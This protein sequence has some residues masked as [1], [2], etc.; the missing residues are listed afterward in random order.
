MWNYYWPLLLIVGS[1]VIY[2]LT[3]KN[4]PHSVDPFLSLTVTYVI[5]A[6]ASLSLYLFSNGGAKELGAGLAELNLTSFLLGLAVVGLETGYIYL[7]RAG[8]DMGK[9]PLTA[10]IALTTILIIIGGLFFAET[11][12][13]KQFVGILI[14]FLGLILITGK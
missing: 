1:N 11:I 14:C 6:G 5:A 8:W 7:Y 12:S 2:N 9:G 10:N 3:T 13:P 4:T